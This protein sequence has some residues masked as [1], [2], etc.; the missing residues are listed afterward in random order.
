MV[1]PRKQRARASA[2]RAATPASTSTLS[3]KASDAAGGFMSDDGFTSCDE[4][5]GSDRAESASLGAKLQ[6][7]MQRLRLKYDALK[8]RVR[9]K[10]D[11]PHVIKL[12]DKIAFALSFVLLC[13]CQYFWFSA[14]A[15]YWVF[16]ATLMPL[17]MLY[18]ILYFRA[19]RYQ[20]FLYDFCYFALALSFVNLFALPA[21]PLAFKV[22]VV[23]AR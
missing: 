2:V 6:R 5:G 19:L 9:E 4:D 11:E 8:Q 21:S 10:R 17:M 16:Y 20:Y 14:P 15:L 13:V 22:C 1:S 3:P 12:L 7:R 23:S 18:R